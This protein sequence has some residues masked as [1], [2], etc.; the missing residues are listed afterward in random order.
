MVN[1]SK[2]IQCAGSDTRPPM[3]DRTDFASWKQRIRLYCQGKENGVNILKSIDKGP[4]Q[5][6]TVQETLAEGTEGAPHLGQERPR[7]YSDLSPEEK[8]RNIKMTMSRM[9]LNSKFVNNM[10]PEWGR[11]VTAVKLN[12]GL[13]DSNYDQL[14]A[15]LKQYEAHA[16]EN[17]MMLDRFT[18]RTMDPLALMSNVSHRQYYLQSSSTPP[19]TYV[20][21]HLAD[22]AH[23]DSGLSPTDNLIENLTNTL[24]RLTQSYK[25]FLPQTNNK[26]RT[27]S[28]TKNQAT[29]QNGKVVV[30]NFQGRLNRGQGIIHEVEV[31]MGM[32]EHRTELGMLIQ[33]SDYFK[34]KMLLMQAQ[35]NGVALDEEQ[36]LFLAGG[37]D[38]DIDEDVD[39]Q[40]APT[41]QTM[42]MANLSSADPVYNEAG[43]SYDSDI[44]SEVHGH[45][46]YQDVVCKQHDEHEMHGNVQLNYVVDSHAD[47]TSDSNMI[48][49][50]QYVKDN[51]VLAQILNNVNS[52]SKDHVKPTVLAPG[53]YAIDV[54]PIPYCLRN[55]REAHLDYLRHLK[56]SVETIH[57]ILEEAKVVR[58]LDS[59]IVFDCRYT[60]HSQKLLE[61]AIG[62]C[63]QDSHQRDKKHA[64]APLIR[65]KQVTF[66]EQCYLKHM[67]GDHSR[68]MNFVKKFI[69]TVRFENDHVGA[70][71]GYGDYVIDDS[72]ISR[73]YYVEGLGHN[74]F[75]IRQ[76]CDFDLEVAFRKH[77]CYVRDTNGVELTK[78]SRGSNLYTIS[79]EDM[80][81]SSL[82]CV[83]SKASKNKSWLWHRHL[84][85]LNFGTI[86]DINGVV[87]RRNRTF[88]E[89]AQT[90]L[91]F[92]KALMFLWVEAVA[93][94]CYTQNRSLIYT[95]RNKTPYKLV[96][97]KKPDLTFFRVF[98]AVCYPTNDSKDLGKLQPTADIG[99]F[100]GYAPSRKVACIKAIRIFIANAASKNM[101]IYQMDVKT[102]FLNGELKEEV[103]APRAWYDT[104]SRFLLDNKF[105]KGAVDPTLFTQK[106]GK[107]ILL[108]Q[109]YFLGDK[110]ASWSSKKQK[111]NVIS[112]REA[113]Y[114]AMSGCCAQ[115]LW[116]R[117]QL[118]DYDFVFNK[119]PLYCDNRSAIALFCNNVQHSRSKYIDIRHHFIQEQ[120]EKGVVELYFV[121]T[122]YQLADIFTKALPRERFKFLLPHL[123]MKRIKL[124]LST[125]PVA[126]AP[127]RLAPTELKELSNQLKELLEKGFIR[128]SSSPWG[129]PMLFVKKKDDSF[130]M[131]IDYRELNKLTVKN[132]YPLSR[133]DDLF[134]QLQVLM[135]REKVIAYASRQLKKHEENYTTYDL[136]LGAI[137]F[138][139]ELNMRQRRW[140][141][142]LSDYDCEIRY[143]PGKGNVVADALSQKDREPLR[144]RSLVMTVHTNLPEKILEAQTE[145]MKEE[146][147]KAENLGRLLKPI[148]KS[149]SNGI[150]CFK[151]RIWLPLLGGIRDMIMHESHK[152]KYSIHPG[153][154]KMYQ[155]L[156]KLYWWPNMK[157]NIA[158]FVSKC[159][160]CA[161]VKA[162]HRKPFGLLH[163]PKIPEWKWEKITMDF[164]S[165]LPRTSSGY[166][167]IWRQSVYIKILEDITRS[168]RNPTE[169]EYRLP[170]RDEWS[171]QEN[172]Q[173]LED[174]LRACIIDFGNSW[175]R[176]LSLVEFSYNNNYH[177]SIKA[178]PFEA[179]YGRNCRSP[180]YWSE[181]G[182]SQLTGPELIRETTEK[183]VQIKNRLLTAISRQKSYTDVRRKPMEFEVGD[184]VML[185]VSPW[186]GVIRFGK[187]GK[188]S[189]RYIKPFEIIER[190][191]PV[192]YKLELPE[193]LYGIYNT[194]HVSNLKKCLVD[195]NLVI[196]LKEIQLHDKLH[197]I[198]EPVEI[199]DRGPEYTWKR[200]DFF[201]RNY[202]HMF[203]SN[204]KTSKM[205]RAPGRRSRK[206][207]R[208]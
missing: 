31:Q 86:N 34:D 56:E 160:T 150:R 58:P 175:D 196:P 158:N 41:A 131:C 90:M 15:Y 107:H 14:Y 157:A 189:L 166:D 73:V 104:L 42:F 133:I 172:V 69:E 44:L 30:Q 201:K 87:E 65:K 79:V 12:R 48:P 203:S 116:M 68:L 114:I 70:I 53:K 102:A 61:Y 146:N 193:K 113:E 35:E 23:L 60:K 121:T 176:H 43:P 63:P 143:H 100:I 162:E 83:L 3:L 94:A 177:A 93:T 132:R 18:Q 74:L 187:H 76:F 99:I 103:Y 135:Q 190:I 111:S 85:H 59:L 144:V 184:M 130:R 137:V 174:M 208:M 96:H 66:A 39:E 112:T 163:Q 71:M 97:N 192:A 26:L 17:K 82:I 141:E 129:A 186:K 149:R 9:K 19:S 136:E 118:T 25:T 78:G 188:L 101:T 122:D 47:Y 88:V 110:L 155:D 1:L 195:E 164:V 45:D 200:E 50:D 178:A 81:K 95:H 115:I 13:K 46:H 20:P 40:P 89:A 33:N 16:N 151:G 75:F 54:E 153:S 21:L 28:N 37:Q 108:V 106:T 72:V 98:G 207:E 7:V 197:F 148:F 64:P 49:Y 204:Q 173:T 109:I 171:K 169:Y 145:A 105:S 139:K 80:M 183:I 38:N 51:A 32:R 206:E 91:I 55:N 120:V 36:L 22:N 62:T 57:E 159:L 24:A 156:K 119:I 205:N 161:K 27:S 168:L 147:V 67:M 185:K 198:E 117:S 140:I 202:P 77:S 180:V 2:D 29:V 191:G 52:V 142:L 194:F 125:T 128:P 154:D 170:P 10:V 123:S 84:N 152:S 11:F 182:D 6:G 179:L 4:F 126:R 167:S 127:Y 199:M 92:S 165:G 134:D 181:V 124:I 5:I 8:D 138:A